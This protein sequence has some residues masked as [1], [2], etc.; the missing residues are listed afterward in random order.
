MIDLLLETDLTDEQQ[1]FAQ[2]IQNS[3]SAL[4]LIVNDILDFS[5]IEA[6]KMTFEHIDFDLV[7]VIQNTIDLLSTA[8]TGKGLGLTYIIGEGTATHLMGDP[9]RLR[10]VLLNLLNNAIKFS[11]QGKVHLEIVQTMDVDQ[12]VK[13]SFLVHDSGIGMSEEA[14]AKLFRSFTQA[15]TTTTRKY[16]GTGLGLAISHKLVELM[17]GTIESYL[18]STQPAYG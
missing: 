14:K 13:L 7:E 12:K 6:G 18:P 10:Q 11:E 3:A 16:G 2:T 1:Q 5:K 4:L 9:T 17:G 15:D 8:A